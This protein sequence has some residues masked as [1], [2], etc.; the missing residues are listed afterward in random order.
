M[1]ILATLLCVCGTLACLGAQ[2]QPERSQRPALP[3]AALGRADANHD[4]K[5]SFEELRVLR[6]RMDRAQF[7]RIDTDGDG[8]LTAADR[9]R[10]QRPRTNQDRFRRQMLS[11]L[12]STPRLVH[13]L[14]PSMVL[15]L[16]SPQMPM[17]ASLSL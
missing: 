16:A 12:L 7:N 10:S 14:R 13:S 8:F 3:G 2:A 17:A 6:P 5:V 1:R 4:G 9:P 11:K 15:G